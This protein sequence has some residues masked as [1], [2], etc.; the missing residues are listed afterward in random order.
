MS[1]PEQHQRIV[2]PGR[3]VQ[4]QRVAPAASMHQDPFPCRANADR[5][6]LH[7]RAAFGR[8]I[9][10]SVVVQ[11][12][13]PQTVRAMVPVRSAE[14]ARGHV[15]PAMAA[16]KRCGTPARRAEALIT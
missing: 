5:D 16:A 15:Q 11:V 8:A 3:A 10:G 4:V 6:R 14:R 12:T 9:A 13:A 7:E 2:V 1:E